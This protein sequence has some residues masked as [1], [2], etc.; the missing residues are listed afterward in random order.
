MK[1]KFNLVKNII[2]YPQYF[3]WKLSGIKSTEITYLGCHSDLWSFDKKN[4]SKFVLEN[5]LEKKIPK[6]YK[7][8][9]KLG[10]IKKEI[11]FKTNV[12]K[13]CNIYCGGH[14][15]SIAY[16]LYEK[17]FN[18]PFT[19]IATGTWIVIFNKK[20]NLGILNEEQEIFA[21]LNVFGKKIPVLRF[22]G[23]REYSKIVKKHLNTKKSTKSINNFLKKNIFA[24]PSFAKGGP[25]KSKK[26][27]ITNQKLINSF[28]EYSNLASLY[29]ALITDYCLNK[30]DSKNSIIVDGGFIKNKLFLRYLSALRTNQKIFVNSDSNGTAMGAFLLCNKKSNYKL[31]LIKIPKH[32]IKALEKYKEQW[33]ELIN[34]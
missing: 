25:F 31:S 8:W 20:T 21:K 9:E 18:K 13:N 14:D 1:K 7:T 24:I 32:T 5:N 4:F 22:M 26:G 29:I 23:G 28:A 27:R 34:S 33:L 30:I 12:F 11:S 17:K 10:K 3:A 2:F 6:L 16:Y 15:S 19:L